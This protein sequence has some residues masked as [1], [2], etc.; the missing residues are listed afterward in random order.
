MGTPPY[1]GGLDDIE[2][3]HQIAIWQSLKIEVHC[4]HTGIIHGYLLDVKKELE[5]IGVIYHTS[6]EW[7]HCKG[8]HTISYCNGNFLT[9][10]HVIK[11]YCKASLWLNC[12]TW[13]FRKEIEAHKLGLIDFF[14]YQ[15]THGKDM[16]SKHLIPSSK[17]PFRALINVPY[18][19]PKPF[20][21]LYNRPRDKFRFGRISRADPV[22]FHK[23]Q[24]EIY[25]KIQSPVPKD[26]IVMG[27]NDKISAHYGFKSSPLSYVTILKERGISQQE[28]YKHCD[29]LIQQASTHEN[30][31]RVGMEA[32]AS[33]S[34]LV[35]DNRGGWK[36]EVEDGITGF[37]CS[38]AEEF[39]EKSTFLANNPEVREQMRFSALNK[40]INTWSFEKAKESWTNIFNEVEKLYGE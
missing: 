35:V 10:L 4:V 13:A 40:L 5:N 29:C 9:N 12:M 11:K 3:W 23:Q 26:G 32:M 19:D 30:L 31:P 37:L 17:H 15:T 6:R 33:G 14:I 24:F 20:T 8:M 36:A 16:I 22:K 2:L 7:A 28:F 25:E 34:V 21:F 38:N 18:F 39:I 27:W 1:W